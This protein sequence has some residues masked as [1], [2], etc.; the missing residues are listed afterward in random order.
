[1]ELLREREEW[2][3]EVLR[4]SGEPVLRGTRVLG[5]KVRRMLREWLAGWFRHRQRG[6]EKKYC[7]S[8]PLP[9]DGHGQRR[10]E[11]NNGGA[12]IMLRGSS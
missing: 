10:W 2:Q 4:K 9:A 7:A 1:M 11:L 12:G 3:M 8:C 6:T 5:L